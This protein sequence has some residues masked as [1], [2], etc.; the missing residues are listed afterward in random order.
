MN[1]NSVI[2]NTL[3]KTISTLNFY[4]TNSKEEIDC[5]LYCEDM[6]SPSFKESDV[7]IP[8]SPDSISND[9]SLKKRG[10]PRKNDEQEEE[11]IM[12]QV[13]RKRK[14]ARNYRE[15]QR[16]RLEQ[17]EHLLKEHE[18]LHK[19]NEILRNQLKEYT[20]REKLLEIQKQSQININSLPNNITDLS[21]AALIH[22]FLYNRQLNIPV[23]FSMT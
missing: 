11:V 19:E 10:R 3:S 18:R 17:Y 14:Y 13:L 15:T 6:S 21:S 20:E 22:Q 1:R 5:E 9:R 2:H 7:S 16:K 4:P 8:S 12:T 23:S